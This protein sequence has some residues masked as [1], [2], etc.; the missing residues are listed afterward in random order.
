MAEGKQRGPGRG[1]GHGE[2]EAGFTLLEVLI[3]LA[4][5]AISLSSLMG[6]QMAAMSA[7]R[8]A[9]DITAAALLAEQLIIDLEFKHREEGWTSSDVDVNGDFSEFGYD[10]HEWV[11]TIH[12]I[13]MPEYNQLMEAKEGADEAAGTD[14]D[15]IMDGG[16]QA[17]GA[18]GMVWAM[19]KSAIENSIR[20]V[21]CTVT[22]PQGDLTQEFSIQTF[23]TDPQG[24]T[25]GLPQ[26]GGETTDE[27]DPSGADE[28]SGTSGTSGSSGGRGGGGGRGGI[29]GAGPM[30]PP[31]LGG[32]G[33]KP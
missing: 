24:L 32:G 1:R 7:T 15:N 25:G 31:S 13:E 22:W 19:V 11:C 21:D 17:F 29:S 20:K 4:I 28:G 10:E 18:L 14:D 12:F 9:R 33:S 23:W 30:L 8:Y 5:L 27:S 3:A 16:D 2:A 26:A 6:S